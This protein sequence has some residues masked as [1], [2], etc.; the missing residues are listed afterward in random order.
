MAIKFG[1]R[2]DLELLVN[3]FF[4]LFPSFFPQTL[5]NKIILAP[6]EGGEMAPGPPEFVELLK[7]A[8]TTIGG[9]VVLRCKVKGFPRPTITWSRQGYGPVTA[10]DRISMEYHDDGTIILTIKNAEMEDTGEYR[11]DAENEYGTAWTEVECLKIRIFW[12]II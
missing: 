2:L 5:L 3:C 10:T 6:A 11:C 8:T 4:T 9:T 1:L 12:S 7:S